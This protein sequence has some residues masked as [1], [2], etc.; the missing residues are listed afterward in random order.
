[1]RHDFGRHERTAVSRFPR[2]PS[3]GVESCNQ[4]EARGASDE[5]KERTMW[6]KGDGMGRSERLHW[7]SGVSAWAVR[8]QASAEQRSAARQ[9]VA[10]AETVR[11]HR[12]HWIGI[13]PAVV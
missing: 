3:L 10:S 8:A 9:D 7:Q 6:N 5:V 2:R 13:F 1:M 12:R 4:S 11:I